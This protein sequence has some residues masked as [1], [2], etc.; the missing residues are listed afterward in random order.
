MRLRPW[1]SRISSFMVVALSLTLLRAQNSTQTGPKDTSLKAEDLSKLVPE[2]VFFAGQLA[3]VQKQGSCGVRFMDGSLAMAAPLERSSYPSW[4]RD[5]YQ[6]FLI[7]EVS[8]AI[9][10]KVLSA[11]A[12]GFGFLEGSKFLVMD[13]GG[14]DKLEVATTKDATL[15]DDMPLQVVPGSG[16]ET[17][18]LCKGRNCV[19]FEVVKMVKIIRPSAKWGGICCTPS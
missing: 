8:I 1:Y 6:G 10:G 12:Y 9:N 3:T 14:Y 11:G 7:T 18:R 15:K 2:R 13:I 16:P 5:K 4:I 17:H 19:E